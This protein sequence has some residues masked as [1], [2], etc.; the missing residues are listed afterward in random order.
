MNSD[1]LEWLDQQQGR[2]SELHSRN[3]NPV[4]P[5]MLRTIS[6]DKGFIRGEGCYLYDAAANDTWTC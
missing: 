4:F 1:F 6:F 2:Q 3:I 5:K